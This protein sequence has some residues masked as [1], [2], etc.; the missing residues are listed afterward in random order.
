MRAVVGGEVAHHEPIAEPRGVAIAAG[1]AD[2]EP[3]TRAPRVRRVVSRSRSG[4]RAQ[5]QRTGTCRGCS[6]PSSGT[7][8]ADPS[9]VPFRTGADGAEAAIGVL[10]GLVVQPEP[11]K[12]GVNA[13][14]LCPSRTRSRC[15][16]RL[17]LSASSGAATRSS[18]GFGRPGAGCRWAVLRRCPTIRRASPLHPSSC[19]TRR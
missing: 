16:Q 5:V 8:P 1:C 4:S 2:G 7:L 15:D 12:P 6:V 10:A 11:K 14:A 3:C 9:R 17:Q 18:V 19:R 13:V